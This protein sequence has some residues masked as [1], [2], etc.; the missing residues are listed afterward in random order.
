TDIA[1]TGGAGWATIPIAFSNGDGT[2][3]GTNFGV[4]SGW[5]LFTTAATQAGAKPVSG[6]FDGDGKT[7][8][9]LIGGLRWGSIPVAFSNGDGTF[10][11]TNLSVTS[12]WTLFTTAATQAGATPVTGDF[13]G[14]AKAD[15]AL[16][17]GVGWG[18]IPVA[19]SNGDG[20]FHATNRAV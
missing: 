7:D 19:F 1:L 3:R 8:I 9:A 16:T 17:S 5:T 20:T 13:D 18:S 12:G 14:D 6:D 15:V 4:T 10:R 2:F 11:G